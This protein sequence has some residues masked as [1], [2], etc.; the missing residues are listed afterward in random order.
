MHGKSL[1]WR[2]ERPDGGLRDAAEARGNLLTLGC[3]A[4]A[5]GVRAV[6]RRAR[7][8]SSSCC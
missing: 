7:S 8:R 1:R 3:G 6:R 4:I 2:K 5:Y